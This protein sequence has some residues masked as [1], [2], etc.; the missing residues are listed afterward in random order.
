[1]SNSSI[2]DLL[3]LLTNTVCALCLCLEYTV[4]CNLYV[5]RFIFD[6]YKGPSAR[7]FFNNTLLREYRVKTKMSVV[8]QKPN[9]FSSS[10]APEC[11]SEGVKRCD[12][13]LLSNVNHMFPTPLRQLL[14]AVISERKQH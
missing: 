2:V 12:V 13:C 4:K 5:L 11:R 8:C 6:L 3:S 14:F 1:M 7:Q 10:D 9:L